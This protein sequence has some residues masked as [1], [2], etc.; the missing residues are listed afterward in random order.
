[1]RGQSYYSYFLDLNLLRSYQPDIFLSTL[2]I[3]AVPSGIICLSVLQL[4]SWTLFFRVLGLGGRAATLYSGLAFVA[5]L[6]LVSLDVHQLP[7]YWY[8]LFLTGL[9]AA[10][11]LKTPLVLLFTA[12]A[13][14]GWV[15]HGAELVFAGILL[16]LIL[17]RVLVTRSSQHHAYWL[18]LVETGLVFTSLLMRPA[19][20]QFDY[21]PEA[22]LT[23]V[24]LLTFD[25]ST[26]I[27]PALYPNALLLQPYVEALEAVGLK[28]LLL[29]L[30]LSLMFV[31]N[32]KKQTLGVVLGG[33]SLLG[34][35]FIV[36]ASLVERS[37]N[38]SFSR[39]LRRTIPGLGL[40][41]LPWSFASM[42]LPV[43]LYYLFRLRRME[44][45]LGALLLLTALTGLGGVLQTPQSRILTAAE[46]EPPLSP[47]GFIVRTFGEWSATPR[48][49]ETLP[50]DTIVASLGASLNFSTMSNVL[51]AD[52]NS[53][54]RTA[55]SQQQ[56]D[57]FEVQ[58]SKLISLARISIP[59]SESPSDY[60]R[61]FKLAVKRS[62]LSPWEEVVRFDDWFGPLNWTASGY[63]YLGP[64]HEVYIDLPEPREVLMFRITLLEESSFDWAISDLQLF[65]LER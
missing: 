22:R 2:S 64:Q 19:A 8:A 27:G 15:L 17:S 4:L 21:P 40:G 51:D 61:G 12:F 34:L 48:H 59:S 37:A 28:L 42:L 43:L 41:Y 16:G 57:F 65:A 7:S 23:P 10:R 55:R 53:S 18:P 3:E 30:V 32:E 36:D 6:L 13:G 5:Q 44:Y 20:P 35:I 14:V 26:L 31:F 9:V 1:M 45:V 29:A 25:S 58:F 33:I 52:G 63:P 47:S 62:V 54:W 38:F 24:S 39:A 49:F 60:P 11:K 56:G 50:R 46:L